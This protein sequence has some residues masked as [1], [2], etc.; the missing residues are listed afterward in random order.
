MIPDLQA[1]ESYQLILLW[2]KNCFNLTL[3]GRNN[4][5]CENRNTWP[6][7]RTAPAAEEPLK[8]RLRAA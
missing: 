4:P 2:S 5:Y 6:V 1:S 7:G 3:L 8:N